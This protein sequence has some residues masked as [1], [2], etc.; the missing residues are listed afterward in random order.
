MN[1]P[2][3]ALLFAL[4]LLSP[5]AAQDPA[6]PGA[7]FLIEV[8][9]Q[10]GKVYRFK[11]TE[12]RNSERSRAGQ[13]EHHNERV[14]RIFRI[15]PR[16]VEKEGVL[17]RF[18]LE[19]MKHNVTQGNVESSYDSTSNPDE[20]LKRERKIEIPIDFVITPQGRIHEIRAVGNE[21]G[22]LTPTDQ[23]EIREGWLRHSLQGM[24]SPYP[25]RK[26]K[27]GDTWTTTSSSTVVGNSIAFRSQNTVAEV[28]PNGR[29][30][31]TQDKTSTAK[32]GGAY[33]E[34]K[35][36]GTGEAE[37]DPADGM[38]QAYTLNDQW[39]A[40]RLSGVRWERTGKTTVTRISEEGAAKP[41]EDGEKQD[42]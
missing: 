23:V 21:T 12:D 17:C 29:I 11:V 38:L 16:A 18:M 15:E 24:F 22:L 5:L 37:L 28:L 6:A 25:T 14:V 3:Y 36:L 39:S 9:P 33:R 13:K 32:P 34:N 31:I 4:S 42:E 40:V 8:K 27:V 35:T 7:E 41:P 30:K 19:S 26:L 2:H 1:H 10:V 20:K